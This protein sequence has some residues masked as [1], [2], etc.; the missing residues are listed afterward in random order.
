MALAD[1]KDR[2]AARRRTA[3]LHLKIRPEAMEK[4]RALCKKYDVPQ[5]E[6]VAELILEAE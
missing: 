6:V 1:L 5:A 4:L 2:V 3:Q